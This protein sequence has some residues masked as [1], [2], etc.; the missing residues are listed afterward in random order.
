MSS[1]VIS[2]DTSGAITLAAPAV[3]GT[4]TATL[5]AATGTVMI[6]GNMPAFSAYMSATQSFSINTWTKLT[7]NTKYFDT[8][9]NFDA[10]TNYRFTPTVAGY[11]Q[12]NLTGSMGD[13][14]SGG[15]TEFGAIYKN[16]SVYG[17]TRAYDTIGQNVNVSNSL[18]VYLNGTT[19]YIEAYAQQ[20]GGTTGR[21]FGGVNTSSFSAALIRSA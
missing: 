10:T 3:S 5:P 4:N 9:S 17:L 11:Y 20:T 16:G 6:S 2:G 8:N 14:G 18:I 12:V 13:S 19:D 1:I 21:F 7:F 15:C